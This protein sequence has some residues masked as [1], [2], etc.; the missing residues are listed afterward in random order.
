MFAA[1][2][3][4]FEFMNNNEIVAYDKVAACGSRAWL[5]ALGVML[6]IGAGQQPAHAVPITFGT[7]IELTPTTFA[8]PLEVTDA[9]EVSEWSLDLT[10]DPT[11]VQVNVSCDPFGGDPYCS[12][13][14]GPVTEGDFFAAG[15]P[16]NLLLPGFV[17]LDPITLMQ[18]GNLF[19][20]QGTY[21]GISPAPSGSGTLAYIQFTLLGSGGSPIVGGG[22]GAGSVSVPEPGTFALLVSGIAWLGGRGL[23]RRGRAGARPETAK[24]LSSVARA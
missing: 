4:A 17:E 16:F 24:N 15:A 18:T 10:Y 7:R 22:D 1:L 19:G 8:L 12:L 3:S 14:T 21:G 13:I 5:R 20:L 11:D 6:L 2:R 9:V 23:L